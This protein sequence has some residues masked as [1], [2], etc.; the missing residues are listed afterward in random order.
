MFSQETMEFIIG[1][2]IRVYSIQVTSPQVRSYTLNNEHCIA[3]GAEAVFFL[4]GYLIA[5]Q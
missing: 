4:N 2:F 1:I 5:R 3:I